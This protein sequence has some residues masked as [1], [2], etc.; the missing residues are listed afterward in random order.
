MDENNDSSNTKRHINPRKKANFF[1]DLFFWWQLCFLFEGDKTTP[2]EDNLC[3][4][5]DDQRSKRLGDKLEKFW[6]EEQSRRSP[7]LWR[8]LYRTFGVKFMIHGL[9]ICQSIVLNRLVNCYSLPQET[10]SKNQ[11]YVYSS[12]MILTTYLV[13]FAYHNVTFRM[14]DLSIKIQ[15]ACRCLIYRKSLKL[16]QNKV[17][18]G[19]VVNLVTNDVNNF[20][21]NV[22]YA[23]Y[24]WLAPLE[25]VI[26]LYLVYSVLGSTATIGMMIILICMILLMYLGKLLSVY[27]MRKLSATDRRLRIINEIIHGIKI[28]KMYAWEKP[29]G[30]LVTQFRKLEIHQIKIMCYINSFTSCCPLFVNH[31]ALFFW[32]LTITLSGNSLNAKHI[33]F[34]SSIYH[35][36]RLVALIF[37]PFGVTF[38]TQT[39]VSVRRIQQFLKSEETS[40]FAL[41]YRN[42]PITLTKICAKWDASSDEYKLNDV[43]LTIQPGQVVAIVGSIGS[44]KT[45][46]L[47]AM[48]NEI[49]HL[50]GRLE[51]GGSISYA[52]QEAW[53]FSGTIKENILFGKDLDE[54]KYHKVV[55]MCALQR[56]F[57]VFPCGD[58]TRVGEK[59]VRLSGGQKARVTLARALYRDVDFYL[60]DDPFSAVDARVGKELFDNCI[61]NYLRN[62]TVVLTTHQLHYLESVD[63]IYVLDNGRVKASGTYEELKLEHLELLPGDS[64]GGEIKLDTAASYQFE[65]VDATAETKETEEIGSVSNL[66]YRRYFKS[67]GK[68]IVACLITLTILLTASVIHG[69][70][71][72][73]SFWVNQE[74]AK[75]TTLTST[76]CLFIYGSL[77]SLVLILCLASALACFK[78]GV[79]L[80]TN[81]HDKM[82]RKI[83]AMPMRFFETNP[84]GRIL[85]RFSKDMDSIDE[86]VPMSFLFTVLVAGE[87]IFIAIFNFVV[88]LKMLIP[89]LVMFGIVC[90]FRVVFLVTSRNLKRLEAR[91]RSPILSHLSSS[92]QGLVTIRAF[93]NQPDQQAKFNGHQDLHTSAYYLYLASSSAFGFWLDFI[94]GLY[95]STVT[96]SFLLIH[97][98]IHGGD[99]GFSIS[100][101]LI[102]MGTLQYGMKKWSDLENDMV[103]VE[104]VVEYCD[105]TPELDDGTK[106]PSELWPTTGKIAFNGVSLRYS[107][108]APLIIN[109]LSLQIDPED[110]IGIVGRTGAGKSSLVS[111]LFRLTHFEGDIKIDGVNIKT[112]PLRRLRSRISIIPQEPTLFSGTIRKNLDPFDEYPDSHLW[113]ALN[114][115]E[116]KTVV[117]DSPAGLSSRVSESGLNFSVGQRQLLCLA[118]AIIRMNKILILDEATA[119]VDFQTDELIQS[120]IRRK[121]KGCTVL[122]VA[123]RLQTVMDC[124]KILVIDAGCAV[125]FDSP[126]KL[127]QNTNGAFYKLVQ[128]SGK[129]NDRK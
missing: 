38:W 44:G 115:V 104:R 31:V 116:L 92:L 1:S 70:Q 72:F 12:L 111:T 105:L 80:A 10:F 7:S 49:P 76:Q 55:E 71:Y 117:S 42:R 125:E 91:A 29:F 54:A 77:V 5:L 65:S 35:S 97:S 50:E 16:T 8:A 102:M 47:Q 103:S 84:S 40:K 107:D 36:L 41:R 73:L 30:T 126:S 118:R 22:Y 110:K 53:L 95:L 48:L 109:R 86:D 81:L 11:A 68:I 33:F 129:N 60:L 127:L 123:H 27:G 96:L 113:E 45:T 25:T 128:M 62:K 28:I 99:V 67:G 87:I 2:T 13:T 69:A 24:L 51:V 88:N 85:N 56:D 61:K 112:L 124:E 20:G 57:S 63:V 82:F 19:H 66:I 93:H 4:I 9:W 64:R 18:A 98:E 114:D 122:T 23:H 78:F 58:L 108:D 59:G 120:T 26:I 14:S 17:T 43:N 75:T 52:P 37:F 94:C 39:I 32:V 119:N 83:V 100:Q 21:R 101:C 89:T 90:Y 79:V 3:E 15:V 6:C 34:M 74:Q 46:L 106:I 121:F